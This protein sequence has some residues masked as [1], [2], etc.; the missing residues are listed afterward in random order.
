MKTVLVTWWCGFIGSHMSVLLLQSD[1]Q[2]IIIDNMSNSSKDVLDGIE[3]ITG[4]KPI[5]VQWDIRDKTCLQELF[6]HYP[7][8]GV[9]H[10]AALKAVW[11]SM[12]KP[13]VYYE[14]NIVG[15]L[16]LLEVMNQYQVYQ[17]V[18]SSSCTVYGDSDKQPLSENAVKQPCTSPY[19]RS[20][21]INEDMLLWLCQS[22]PLRVCSLR[23]FNPIWAHPSGIIGEYPTGVPANLL[24]YVIKTL[25]G[26]YP[27][28]NIRWNDYPTPD[29]TAIRDY[30]HIMDLV[31]AHLSALERIETQYPWKYEVFNLWT[32]TGSSV[33]DIIHIAEQV[34]WKQ[35][36]YQIQPRRPWDVVAAYADPSKAKTVLWWSC[37]YSV[38]DAIRDMWN[39]EGMRKE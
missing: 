39:F 30:I 16:T 33:M 20:K 10:F 14:N 31:Q 19:G 36:P 1:Y 23:Y 9:I 32:G 5:F 28:L 29:G 18:F 27:Y 26:T 11:E 15:T 37:R 2:V 17:C 3:K 12:E 22:T 8:D 38:A 6:E 34:T 25:K 4:K 13:F 24:P 35:L 7:I 21:S